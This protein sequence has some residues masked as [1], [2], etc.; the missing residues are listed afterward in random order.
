MKK[1]LFTLL[2][3]VAVVGMQKN[4]IASTGTNYNADGTFLTPQ[5]QKTK[6]ILE[7][8]IQTGLNKYSWDGFKLNISGE[9]QL[10]SRFSVGAGAGFRHYFEKEGNLIP[11]FGVAKAYLKEKGTTPFISVAAGYAF[12]TKNQFKAQGLHAN[13]LIGYVFTLA[14]GVQMSLGVNV[15]IQQMIFYKFEGSTIPIEFREITNNLGITLG[16][17]F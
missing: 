7:A 2:L 9:Y 16:I 14:D 15:E 10:H 5:P 4:G 8:G 3:I 1:L 6:A 13:G 17:L 12:S 11:I